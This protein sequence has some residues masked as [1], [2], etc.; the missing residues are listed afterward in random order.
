M[1]TKMTSRIDLSL[2]AKLILTGAI[3]ALIPWGPVFLSGYLPDLLFRYFLFT[4]G[5]VAWTLIE[6]CMHRWAFHGHQGK[7]SKQKD[8]FN[9]NHHHT[10]PENMILN[11]LHRTLSVLLV[12]FCCTSLFAGPA[13]LVYPAGLVSGASVYILMHWFIHQGIATRFFPV[14]V[15]QHIW[16]H[17]KYPNKCFGVTSIFW[18]RLFKSL[19]VNF[20]LLPERII[21]FYYAH[22]ALPEEELIKT[23][24][25]LKTVRGRG[26]MISN[27]RQPGQN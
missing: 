20:G 5:W 1:T 3:P 16:H 13:W 12:L 22:E 26:Q 19:P 15:R 9:H 24:A 8:I 27:L 25:R 6:Y 11:N 17:C 10:H 21:R 18:D 4:K 2:R 23:M 7:G 14:L